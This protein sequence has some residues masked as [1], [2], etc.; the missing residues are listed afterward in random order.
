[1]ELIVLSGI[2]GAGKTTFYAQRFF[3]THVR[4]SLDLLK[5]RSR[6][7]TV[8]FACLAAQQPVVIDNTNP[9]RAQRMRYAKL[10]AAA[11][12]RTALYFFDVSVRD[13]VGR[14]ESRP[15]GARVP[16]VAIFGTAKKFERPT[17][18][19]AFDRV[20]FVRPDRAGGFVVEEQPAPQQGEP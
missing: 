12:F 11:K 20:F 7:D 16:K 19:E 10:G 17:G 13:A 5:T 1:M 14:N 8:L 6:E 15:A 4:I 2:Q 18:D 9:T 3:A